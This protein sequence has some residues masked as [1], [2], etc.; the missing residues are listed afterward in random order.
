MAEVDERNPRPKYQQLH[1]ILADLIATQLQPH[2]PFPSEAELQERHL[3][4]RMTVRKAVDQLVSEGRLYRVA[5]VGTFVAEHPTSVELHL[6]SFTEDIEA[7]GLA[8][9]QRTVRIERRIADPRLARELEIGPGD[10]VVHLER[11]RL[12][13]ERLICFERSDLPE[14]LVPGLVAAWTGGSL[15]ELLDVRYGLRPTWSQQRIGA[16]HADAV[17]AQHLGLELGAPLLRIHQA[18]FKDDVLVESCTSLYRPDSY[19]LSV[20]LNGS[21]L[22]MTP[23]MAPRSSSR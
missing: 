14:A 1:A 3:L 10:P 21:G 12:A 4:S 5:G 17:V 18:A 7:L 13:D 15:F 11:V 23:S 8:P 16:V 6:S 20:V 9:G 19:E 22:A 2:Q